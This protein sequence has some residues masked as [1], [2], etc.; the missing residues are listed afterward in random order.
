MWVHLFICKTNL[1]CNTDAHHH[2]HLALLPP[3]PHLL[4]RLKH[5]PRDD[6]YASRPRLHRRVPRIAGAGA[7]WIDAD[8]QAPCSAGHTPYSARPVIGDADSQA[9]CSAD[10]TPCSV[11][12]RVGHGP[13]SAGHAPY[14]AWQVA[15]APYSVGHVPYS[16]WQVAHAPYSVGHAPYSARLG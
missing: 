5:V 9:P 10:H 12:Q 6:D 15:H 1:H 3:P 13:C 4:R 7:P 14:S 2:L 8:G 16:A 11:R